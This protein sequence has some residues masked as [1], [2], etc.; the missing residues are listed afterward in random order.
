MGLGKHYQ[1]EASKP[2]FPCSAVN[3]EATLERKDTAG[4]RA[5]QA[6]ILQILGAGEVVGRNQADSEGILKQVKGR[7]ERKDAQ[8]VS[9]HAL[10]LQEGGTILEKKGKKETRGGETQASS[11]T[12][13]EIPGESGVE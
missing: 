4:K 11:A 8:A 12:L 6:R 7:E 13:K 10:L 1:I 9:T 5:L 2:S 3:K